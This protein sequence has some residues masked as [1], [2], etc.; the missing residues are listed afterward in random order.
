MSEPIF[1]IPLPYGVTVEGDGVNRTAIPVG[2]H[3]KIMSGGYV[4]LPAG[5]CRVTVSWSGSDSVRAV[6]PLIGYPVILPAGGVPVRDGRDRCEG[7][8]Q[9]PAA[10]RLRQ[11][12]G[13]GGAG[14]HRG[15]PR[16]PRV[17]PLGVV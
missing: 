5:P 2:D 8:R 11:A 6:L 15:V 14:H 9:N 13:E 1:D 3:P 10:K 7:R 17:A 16:Q 4:K 12:V